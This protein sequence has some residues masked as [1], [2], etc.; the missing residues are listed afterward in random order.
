MHR[1]VVLAFGPF[2]YVPSQRALLRSSTRVTLPAR[3][4]EILQLLI[5]RAGELVTKG[6]LLAHAWPE[7]IVGEGALRVHISRLRKI[8]DRGPARH[9]LPGE[10]GGPRLS[11]CCAGEHGARCPP[12]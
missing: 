12:Q 4:S 10:C 5:E 6:E 11:L 3:A 7:G 8:L 1:P 9:S 2:R